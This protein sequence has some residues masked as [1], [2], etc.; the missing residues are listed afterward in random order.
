M[1]AQAGI[2]DLPSL[3]QSKS[4]LPAG[5][6]PRALDPGAGV[7]AGSTEESIIRA[8]GITPIARVGAIGIKD[9]KA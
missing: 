3:Q 2:H 1:P 4:W 5:A 8:L 7:T 9:L 6:C